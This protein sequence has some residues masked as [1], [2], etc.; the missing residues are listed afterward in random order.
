MNYYRNLTTKNYNGIR[1]KLNKVKFYVYN[2]FYF[3]QKK[4]K[5]TMVF[6]NF[7]LMENS[8]YKINQYLILTNLI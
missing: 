1:F 3:V 4:N 2:S 5:L 6:T 7:F 8:L